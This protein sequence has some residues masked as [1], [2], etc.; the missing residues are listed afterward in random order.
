MNVGYVTLSTGMLLTFALGVVLD[1]R[2]LAWCGIVLPI[3]SL[4]ALFVL[5]ETPLWLA[6]HDKVNKAYK[7]LLWLRGD[8]TIARNELNEY[9]ARVN[10]EKSNANGHN[11]SW[12]DYTERPV[13]KPIV[14]IFAFILLFNIS[15]TYLIFQYALDIIS[16]VKLSISTKNMTVLLSAIRLI[17]TIGFCWLFMRVARR[18]IYII[19]G[20][21][22]T[23]STLILAAFLLN[24]SETQTIYGLVIASSLLLIYVAINTGFMIAP[25]FLTG[26]EKC[27]FLFSFYH[28]LNFTGELLPMRIRGRLA[29]LIYT[30]F[31]IVTFVLNKIFPV[32]NEYIGIAGILTVF[33]IASLAT[34]ALVYFMVP[35]TKGKSLLQIEEHFQQHGWIYKARRPS[36]TTCS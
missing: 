21:G 14:I 35:E 15:G 6:R 29:G 24:P 26:E 2:M 23:I 34:T 12:K 18:K 22:S 10:Q 16:Q 32:C 28:L 20:I 33:G 3:I 11:V 27:S 13:L 7:N 25:G 5:P 31:S 30:F 4:L 19:S 9:L 8:A 1:W 36:Q 17:V